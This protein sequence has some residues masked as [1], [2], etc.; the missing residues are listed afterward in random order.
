MWQFRYAGQEKGLFLQGADS[1]LW[2]NS[3]NDQRE[4]IFLSCN[5]G[6]ET[7]KRWS[8]C[9]LSKTPFFLY[10]ERGNAQDLQT[11]RSVV[12]C[13]KAPT[14]RWQ[15]KAHHMANKTREGHCARSC[16][17]NVFVVIRTDTRQIHLALNS[18]SNAR[19]R[20]RIKCRY[21]TSSKLETLF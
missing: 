7:W 11:I 1:I 15:P 17:T 3:I 21:R 12:G 20:V 14:P 13:S 18:P 10:L 19:E 5:V 9:V 2:K 8:D 16:G 6:H 4:S